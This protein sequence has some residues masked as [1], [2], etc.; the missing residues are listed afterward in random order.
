[1][2]F[3]SSQRIRE[4]KMGDANLKNWPCLRRTEL[5][6]RLRWRIEIKKSFNVNIY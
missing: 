2:I 3:K 5:G 1:M 6:W 4:R